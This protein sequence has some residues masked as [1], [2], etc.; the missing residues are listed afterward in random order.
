MIMMKSIKR[1][2]YR[3]FKRLSYLWRYSLNV[4]NVK[5]HLHLAEK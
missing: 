3:R 2:A 4:I 1:F 5:L